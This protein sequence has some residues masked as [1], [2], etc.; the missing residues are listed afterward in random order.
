MWR[1]LSLQERWNLVTGT[2]HAIASFGLAVVAVVGLYKVAPIIVYQVE[3]QEREA[4]GPIAVHEGGSARSQAAEGFM[5][6][7]LDWWTQQ[8]DGHQRILELLEA[9]GRVSFE[10][11]AAEPI[12]GAPEIASDHLVVTAPAGAGRPE[13][14]RIPVNEHAPSPNQYLQYKINHGAFAD[15]PAAERQAVE[16]AIASYIHNFMVPK[17]PPAFVEG[18]MSRD[19]L[20][21]AIAD[22]QAQ[23]RA[24]IKHL[25]ALRSVIEV[26]LEACRE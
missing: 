1:E 19:E 6:E 10:L 14:V 22:G 24:A 8:V 5:G 21:Q 25:R 12:R 17:A 23:R 18:D 2:M 3:Q 4:Q 9:P 11:A 16:G 15:L 13:V 7:A 26:G 20:R